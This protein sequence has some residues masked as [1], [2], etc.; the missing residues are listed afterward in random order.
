MLQKYIQLKQLQTQRD[1][2]IQSVKLLA[3]KQIEDFQILFQNN[4]GDVD[5]LIKDERNRI[6][7]MLEEMEISRYG[8]LNGMAEIRQSRLKH[9]IVNEKQTLD[10]LFENGY[11]NAVTIKK[12]VL[13]SIANDT[14]NV[15]GV[16]SRT[17]L[18]LAIT[19]YDQS[20]TGQPVSSDI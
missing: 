2:Y 15:P 16:Y 17:E 3:E 6:F 5:E 18:E 1:A 11:T 10:F 14:Y 20:E 8:D 19:I 13:N 4:H 12:A 9:D 7:S